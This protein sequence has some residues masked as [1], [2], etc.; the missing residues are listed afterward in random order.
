MYV[1]NNIHTKEVFNSRVGTWERLEEGY[2]VRV[3]EKKGKGESV[4]N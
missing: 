1:Y 3:E 4:I 2:V